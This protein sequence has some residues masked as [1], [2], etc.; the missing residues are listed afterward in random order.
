M[1][2]NIWCQKLVTQD[3]DNIKLQPYLPRLENKTYQSIHQKPKSEVEH[4]NVEYVAYKSD[5]N[6]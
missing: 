6:D 5:K 4:S 3:A 1:P 2:K